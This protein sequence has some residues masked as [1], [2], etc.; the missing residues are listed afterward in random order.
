[1][2]AVYIYYV[3]FYL[4]AILITINGLTALIYLFI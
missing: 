1:M 3:N 4:D 2:C